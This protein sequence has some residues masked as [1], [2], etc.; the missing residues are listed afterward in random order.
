MSQTGDNSTDD[1]PETSDDL[2]VPALSEIIADADDL[3]A[4]IENAI[5]DRDEYRHVYFDDPGCAVAY[6]A[7]ELDQIEDVEAISALFLSS[8]RSRDDVSAAANR[9]MHEICDDDLDPLVVTDGT[10]GSA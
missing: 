8:P 10:D 1:R 3:D 7:L 2:D 6:A 9:R 5:P 4:A